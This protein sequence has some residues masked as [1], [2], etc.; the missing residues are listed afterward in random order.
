MGDDS[1]AMTELAVAQ[2][3]LSGD[4]E[5]RIEPLVAQ[6]DAWARPERRGARWPI[7]PWR[8]PGGRDRANTT[9]DTNTK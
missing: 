2:Y 7:R 5:Y 9:T 6:D 1:E 3:V 4:L 8:P